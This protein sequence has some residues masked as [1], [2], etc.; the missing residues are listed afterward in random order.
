MI[1]KLVAVKL[2][3]FWLHHFEDIIILKKYCLSINSFLANVSI[4]HLLKTSAL[5]VFRGYKTEKL[6]K[7]VLT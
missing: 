5:F 1:I 4:S 2:S 3:I 6:L 7:D